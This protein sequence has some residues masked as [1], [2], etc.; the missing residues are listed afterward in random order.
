L[1]TQFRFPK[2]TKWLYPENQGFAEA[3]LAGHEAKPHHKKEVLYNF[4][5]L[6]MDFLTAPWIFGYGIVGVIC[7][8]T[9]VGTIFWTIWAFNQPEMVELINIL[10]PEHDW[11]ENWL[12]VPILVFLVSLPMGIGMLRWA[13][14]SYPFMKYESSAERHYH[15]LLAK[16]RI[17]MAK[18]E[19]LETVDERMMKIRFSLK[20]GRAVGEY[21]TISTVAKTLK[22]GD[23]L[24]LFS[25]GDYDILL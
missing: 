2:E 13:L 20:N 17:W 6:E 19:R 18:V 9:V 25:H 8:L 21:K 24:V 22:P 14:H 15:L 11:E 16:G 5:T 4:G 23:K 10:S 12:F 1:A 7:L 3:K